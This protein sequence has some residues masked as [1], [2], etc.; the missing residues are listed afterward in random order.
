MIAVATALG[1]LL[2]AAVASAGPCPSQ[3]TFTRG[4]IGPDMAGAA[5]G[6]LMLPQYGAGACPGPTCEAYEGYWSVEAVMKE[7]YPNC[8]RGDWPDAWQPTTPVVKL[9]S[10][11]TVAEWQRTSNG[12]YCPDPNKR[13]LPCPGLNITTV[14]GGKTITLATCQ[15]SGTASAS[16]GW[17]G[18]DAVADYLMS[19]AVV[20][21]F[22]CGR[23]PSV[24]GAIQTL[25][26]PTF[27]AQMAAQAAAY[28]PNLPVLAAINRT[29][30]RLSLRTR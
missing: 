4:A 22:V 20:D 25:V 16:G 8:T 18:F 19:A 3:P 24:T 10:R 2:V 27:T 17:G 28:P 7:H 11:C 23:M 29:C 30:G 1:L 12:I 26:C 14:D 21:P 9:S 13:P 5:C 15:Q 6:L